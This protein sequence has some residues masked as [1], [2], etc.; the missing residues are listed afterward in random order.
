MTTIIPIPAFRDNYIWAVRDGAQRGRRRS[1]RRR[2]G[3]RVARRERRAT[4]GD[5]RHASSRR[6]R[7]RHRGALRE[8]TTCRCSARRASRFRGARTRCAR[9]IASTCRASDSPV[10]LLDI[11][12]HTAGHIAYSHDGRR[13]AAVLRRHA[14]RRGLRPHLRRH[15]RADVDVAVEARRAAGGDAR[16]LRSRIHA[17]EPARSRRRSSPTT[18]TCARGSRASGRSAIGTCRRCRRRSATSSRPI[19]SCARDCPP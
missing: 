16:V 17:G 12:G 18:P 6:S 7:R 2:A 9:A 15:A 19:R 10:A 13:S 14:V 11:P 5:H 3:A 1:R 4:V 8:R